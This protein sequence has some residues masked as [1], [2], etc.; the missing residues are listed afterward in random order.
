MAVAMMFRPQ[1]YPLWFA[2][3]EDGDRVMRQMVLG[4]SEDMYGDIHVHLEHGRARTIVP[5]DAIYAYGVSDANAIA[6][7]RLEWERVHRVDKS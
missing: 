5:V 7:C 4:W 3:T 1:P 2:W 6:R